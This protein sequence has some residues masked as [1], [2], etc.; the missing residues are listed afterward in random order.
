MRYTQAVR[1]HAPLPHPYG[2]FVHTTLTI[3]SPD[4]RRLISAGSDEHRALSARVR[5]RSEAEPPPLRRS[6]RSTQFEQAD[7]RRGARLAGATRQATAVEAR[8]SQ[9]GSASKVRRRTLLHGLSTGIGGSTNRH[10]GLATL[11]A[12]RQAATI[13]EGQAWEGSC[14][15]S[16]WCS[17]LN[18]GTDGGRG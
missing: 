12:P 16:G 7:P 13:V 15:P 9:P 2:L 3:P 8:S 5:L 10:A 18:Y 4:D 17:G 1:N 14:K 11:V 6:Q